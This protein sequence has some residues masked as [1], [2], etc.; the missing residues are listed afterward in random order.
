M[1]IYR[2]GYLCE[3]EYKVEEKSRS[4]VCFLLPVTLSSLS[5]YF[6]PSS[7]PLLE[8]KVVDPGIN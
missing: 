1:I 8:T 5:P 7:W 2:D 6:V 3:N 4:F